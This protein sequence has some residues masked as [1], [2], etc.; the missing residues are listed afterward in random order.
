[1]GLEQKPADA[2]PKKRLS[3]G[4]VYA[5]VYK[6]HDTGAAHPESPERCDAI[7]SALEAKEFDGKLRHIEPRAATEDEI[8]LCHSALYVETVK[9][10][11][12]SGRHVLSTGDTTV[13]EK[14]FDVA[15]L[16]AGGV[17][18][19]V[20]DV[21]AGRVKNAFCVVR[22][23]GHHAMASIGMGF[24]VFNNV[25]IGARYAQHQHKIGKVLIV[26]WDVHH[27]NGTQAI[28]Y[29]DGSVFFFSTHLYPWYPGTGSEAETG[30][31]KGLG[32]ILNCPFP[33]GAD[34]EEIVGAFTDKLVPAANR[35]KPDLVMISAGFDSRGG[36]PLGHFRLTDDDFAEL[37]RIVLAIA[38]EHAGG[39]V[40]SV[41][42][43]GYDLSGLAAATAAHVRTLCAD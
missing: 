6:E 18:R 19:A 38:R 15:L 29:E 4:L 16:A 22:P 31:G 1:M 13:C 3:T 2:A 41:L 7:M 39:R 34:R 42:E 20:D 10:D 9:R 23:P 24:C 11:I 32:C 28:F 37:T 33:A 8:Q 14:S 21:L 5:P 40:I 36:D 27:G 26:D 25:A 35:F 30:H 17:C 12:A 43:G